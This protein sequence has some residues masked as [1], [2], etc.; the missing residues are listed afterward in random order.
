ME[1]RQIDVAT[2]FCFSATFDPPPI[3]L[4]SPPALPARLLPSSSRC[5]TIDDGRAVKYASLSSDIN[6]QSAS[7]S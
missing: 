1:W 7:W 6:T 5:T 4:P 2:D 3:P